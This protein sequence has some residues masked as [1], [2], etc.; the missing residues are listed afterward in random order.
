VKP[1]TLLVAVALL[2]SAPA[3]KPTSGDERLRRVQE[4]RAEIERELSQLR[5][6]EKSLLGEVER[7]ELETR[8]RSEELRETRLMLQETNARLDATVARVKQLE[9]SLAVARPELAAR[10]RALYKL[11]ELSYLRLLL[12]VDRPVDL[13]R[14]YR[15]VATLARRDNLR[16]AGFRR[17][18]DEV[19]HQRAEL[20]ARTEQALRLRAELQERRRRLDLERRRKTELL[21]SIVERKELNAAYLDELRDA[22]ANLQRFLE[23]LLDERAVSV[24]ITVFKGALPWPATGPVAVPFG[25]RKH[26]RFD[27]YTIQNGIEIAA[28]PDAPVRAVHEGTVVFADRFRGYGPMVVVDHGGKHHTLYAHLGELDVHAGQRVATGDVLGTVSPP[29]LDERGLYFEIRFQGKPEDPQDW[30]S[31]PQRAGRR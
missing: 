20:E 16:V 1:L 2:Q 9:S 31:R 18:L 23:G 10:A 30:L 19:A 5:G 21:T 11:G 8:L 7:L 4:R 25:R 29:E 13:V 15:Y 27:T 12:S 6:R 22:E 3:P 17:D 28:P 24:P 14:G 26:P